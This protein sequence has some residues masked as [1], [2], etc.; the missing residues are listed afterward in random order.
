MGSL[1]AALGSYLDA[2]AAGGEW[3]VRLED[4]DRTRESPGAADAIL[5][6]LERF[7]L[8]WDGPVLR[9]SARAEA[10]ESALGLLS[11]DGL[12]YGCSCTRAEIADNSAAGALRAPRRR[13]RAVVAGTP[14]EQRYAGRCRQGPA[15]PQSRLAVRFRTAGFSPVTIEDRLQSPITQ[16]VEA[17]LG[18]FVLRRR[19]GFYAYQL[20]VV[21][22]DAA[23]GITDVVR[24]LDLYD[25]TPRQR[26]LQH[27]LHAPELRY[28]HLPLVVEGSGAKLSKSRRALPADA[29][30]APALLSTL[31][32][33]LHHPPPEMLRSAPVAEQLAWAVSAWNPKFLQGVKTIS[34]TG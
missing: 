19:D 1:L 15:R 13:G 31:L 26:L 18:D 11:R 8:C 27:A 24:G 10:Y 23:Q 5:A 17:D 20:A 14:T 29:C 25:N 28:L 3:L 12:S 6:T 21:V 33:W 32:R 30:Q 34:S 7:G 4:V 22:D 2:R 16:D 9:Q